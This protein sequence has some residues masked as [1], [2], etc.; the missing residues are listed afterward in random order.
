MSNTKNSD[1]SGKAAQEELEKASAQLNT[2]LDHLDASTTAML[3]RMKDAR[4]AGDVDEDRARLAAR[5]DAVQ[6][7]ADAL[8]IAAKEA[9]AALDVAIAEVRNAL[10][11]V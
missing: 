1:S 5:L 10:G 8:E 6:A 3:A 7:R 11:E 2:A 9:G 4:D